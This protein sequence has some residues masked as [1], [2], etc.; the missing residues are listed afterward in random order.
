MGDKEKGLPIHTVALFQ[1]FDDL[2]TILAV[3]ASGRL[4]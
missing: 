4:V 1:Q 2:V 3:K